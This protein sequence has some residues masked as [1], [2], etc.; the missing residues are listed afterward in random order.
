[1]VINPV[2]V[3]S[4]DSTNYGVVGLNDKGNTGIIPYCNEGSFRLWNPNSDKTITKLKED[5]DK[6]K[7]NLEDAYKTIRTDTKTIQDL[8]KSFTTQNILN[9]K[10]NTTVFR[11]RSKVAKNKQIHIDKKHYAKA[12]NELELEITYWKQLYANLCKTKNSTVYE[13]VKDAKVC[14]NI[15]KLLNGRL[16]G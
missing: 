7:E 16:E 13:N 10:L 2:Q 5:I 11:L 3:V 15:E 14:E 8:T 4:L 6:L 1:M 9:N 12:F